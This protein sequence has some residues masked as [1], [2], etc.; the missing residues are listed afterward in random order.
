[1]NP[2]ASAGGEGAVASGEHATKRSG[3]AA[4]GGLSPLSTVARGK[5]GGRTGENGGLERFLIL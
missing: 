1:M 5:D 3:A 2:S 4:R